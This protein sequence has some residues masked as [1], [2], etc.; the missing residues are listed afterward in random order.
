MLLANENAKILCGALRD[1]QH[2]HQKVGLHDGEL[3]I[4]THFSFG[5]ALRVGRDLAVRR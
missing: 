4:S 1:K 2:L 3:N 5:S